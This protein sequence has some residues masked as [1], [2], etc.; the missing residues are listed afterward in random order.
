MMLPHEPT[1]PLVTPKLYNKPS[2]AGDQDKRTLHTVLTI[3]LGPTYKQAIPGLLLHRL[4]TLIT[5]T[6]VHRY[7]NLYIHLT[8]YTIFSTQSTY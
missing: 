1:F 5:L 7:I 4:N 2:V 8:Y 6:E 3:T